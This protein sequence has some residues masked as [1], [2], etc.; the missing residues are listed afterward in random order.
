MSELTS[1]YFALS[2]CRPAQAIGDG[3]SFKAICAF[4]LGVMFFLDALPAHLLTT[5]TP[6][7]PHVR[8]SARHLPSRPAE[9][10]AGM[11]VEVGGEV[12][13]QNECREWQRGS[14]QNHSPPLLTAFEASADPAGSTS[15][16]ESS[17]T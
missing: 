4:P 5:V 13:P 16:S 11:H 10:N 15:A 3:M 2:A 17:S 1:E 14:G 8:P 6:S 12:S 9:M 7:M